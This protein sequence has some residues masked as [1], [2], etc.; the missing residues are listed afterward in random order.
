MTE[1][2][3]MFIKELGTTL[4]IVSLAMQRTGVTREEFEGWKENKFFMNELKNVNDMS[5]DYVENRLLQQI[6]QGELS[7]IQFYLKTKGKKRGY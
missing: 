7:A 1:K 2:Q 4:G 5:L 6:N 3:T